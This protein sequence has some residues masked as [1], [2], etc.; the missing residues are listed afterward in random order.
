MDLPTLKLLM[1]RIEHA[2]E[3]IKNIVSV[4]LHQIRDGMGNIL[5]KSLSCLHPNRFN[6][7]TRP[8]NASKK[9][10]WNLVDADIVIP[11]TVSTRKRT[12][13]FENDYQDIAWLGL[14]DD[15]SAKKMLFSYRYMKKAKLFERKTTL[16]CDG[17][18]TFTPSKYKVE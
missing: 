9:L 5:L 17:S 11:E 7:S 12:L 13:S 8:S 10:G 1:A 14:S 18:I 2:L 15:S 6:L 4:T 3:T 16:H